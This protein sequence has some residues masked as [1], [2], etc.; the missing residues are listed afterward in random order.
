MFERLSDKVV[1]R[2]KEELDGKDLQ[3]RLVTMMK[4]LE[5]ENFSPE[6]EVIDAALQIRLLNCPF[7]SVALEKKAVCSLD[8]NLI[9]NVLNVGVEQQECIHGGDTGC[10]YVAHLDA[11]EA[12]AL[13]PAFGHGP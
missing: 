9:S 6:A 3:D 1:E 11:S 7:R 2:R 8:A 10:S 5:E 13:S 12:Q 4:L